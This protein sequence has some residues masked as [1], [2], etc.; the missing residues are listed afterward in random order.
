MRWLRG[1]SCFILLLSWSFAY[2]HIPDEQRIEL[3][4]TRLSNL[5]RQNEINDKSG[6]SHLNRHIFSLDECDLEDRIREKGVSFIPDAEVISRMEDFLRELANKGVHLYVAL[7]GED[8]VV[9]ELGDVTTNISFSHS[10]QFA[11]VNQRVSTILDEIYGRCSISSLGS[12]KNALLGIT[13]VNWLGVHKNKEKSAQDLLR[14]FFLRSV[15]KGPAF[16]DLLKLITQ[17]AETQ[18][19]PLYSAGDRNT[20]FEKHLKLYAS[21]MENYSSLVSCPVAGQ[22]IE[23]RK[24]KEPFV[25]DELIQT[26]ADYLC[27]YGNDLSKDYNQE[28]INSLQ[29]WEKKYY[30]EEAS[31]NDNRTYERYLSA[32][33][34]RNSWYKQAAEK[35]F[36]IRD[37]ENMILLAEWFNNSELRTLTVGQKISM[38]ITIAKGPMNGDWVGKNGEGMALRIMRSIKKE[39]AEDFLELLIREGYDGEVLLNEL[40]SGIDDFGGADNF[41]AFINELQRLVFAKNNISTENAPDKTLYRNSAYQFVWNSQ[42]MQILPVQIDYVISRKDERTLSVERKICVYIAVV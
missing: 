15:R 11:V 9:D 2:A 1:L 38:L 5:I 28:A 27:T 23:E 35:T 19:V 14:I 20:A 24:S 42:S 39:E 29:A 40:F 21:V 13:P 41:T 32:L 10:D 12:G 33:Q 22:F 30:F 16:P 18:P 7:N 26:V 4:I 36:T 31:Q 3:G 34:K 25:S 17:R 37:Q 6:V 8:L